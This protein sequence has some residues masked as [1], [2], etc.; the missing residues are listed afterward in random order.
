M[1]AI[2]SLLDRFEVRRRDDQ[3]AATRT[4]VSAGA[5][6]TGSYLAMNACATL[7]A[8]FGLLQTSP[9]IIGAMLVAMLFGPLMGIALGLA[10]ADMRLLARSQVPWSPSQSCVAFC[11]IVSKTG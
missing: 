2:A 10:R 6:I 4:A 1:N 3:R 8:G 5:A 11:T 9:A 7:L